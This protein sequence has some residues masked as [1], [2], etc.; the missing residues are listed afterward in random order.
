M[1]AA[2]ERFPNALENARRILRW[3]PEQRRLS[4]RL[5][6]DWPKRKVYATQSGATTS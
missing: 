5:F 2:H 3:L 1:G 4:V 6:S